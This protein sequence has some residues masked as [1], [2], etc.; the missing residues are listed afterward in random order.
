VVAKAFDDD[1][2]Q[3][4]EMAY[5]EALAERDEYLIDHQPAAPEVCE[6]KILRQPDGLSMLLKSGAENMP[7][8]N[9]KTFEPFAPPFRDSLPDVNRLCKLGFLVC[10]GDL[11]VRSEAAS[12]TDEVD[13]GSGKVRGRQSNGLNRNLQSAH[14]PCK[15]I[16]VDEHD[17]RLAWGNGFAQSGLGKVAGRYDRASCEGLQ[18]ASKLGNFAAAYRVKPSLC[19]NLQM[20]VTERPYARTG[21]SVHINAAV[22]AILC[23]GNFGESRQLQNRLD[24]VLEL[25]RM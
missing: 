7:M 1:V 21:I 10:C 14:Y 25:L 17:G 9:T 11:S 5:Q 4:S 24:E 19:L 3:R 2:P 15:L 8:R 16:A 18:A 13:A 12:I 20:Q 22:L 23:D 6:G